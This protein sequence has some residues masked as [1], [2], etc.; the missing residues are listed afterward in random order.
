[1][2]EL[3]SEY[4]REQLIAAYQNEYEYLI[5]DDLDLAQEVSAEEHLEWIQSLSLERLKRE[6]LESIDMDNESLESDE[7]E[8]VSVDDYM[9]RWLY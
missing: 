8:T 4:S 2:S 5:H 6:I 7:N 9:N 3:L 1:M